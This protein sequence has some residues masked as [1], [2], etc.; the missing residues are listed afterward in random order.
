MSTVTRIKAR[1][2]LAVVAGTLVLAGCG[3][4]LPGTAALVGADRV[5][6]DALQSQVDAVLAYRDGQQGSSVRTQLPTITQQVLSADVLHQL[7][8][9]AVAR[10]H[11]VVDEKAISDQ[12]AKLDPKVLTGQGL[13]FVTPDTLPQ[14]VR[15]E[16]IIAQLGAAAWD[17]LAITADLTSATD[18]AD[19]EAKA[20]RMAQSPA[21][22]SAVVAEDTANGLQAVSG[23]PL[24]PA[25]LE[26]LAG[27]PV[28]A[29]PAGSAVAFTLNQKWQV[30]RILTRTTTAAPDTAPDAVSAA[31]AK[32]NST[33]ALGISL[34]SELAGNPDVR[35][36]PRYGSWDTTQGQVLAPAA[37]PTAIVVNPRS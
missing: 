33:Y 8:Q 10:T 17:G 16:L 36:N 29:V 1:L 3:S 27:S 11:L 31:Q 15:D 12:L 30:A 23:Y 5:S 9:T 32:P 2:A 4:A 28:F 7:A 35:I 25:A 37:P 19:A 22:A 20:K 18:Q 6:V 21:E 13:T 34:L 14:F 24:S 26:G